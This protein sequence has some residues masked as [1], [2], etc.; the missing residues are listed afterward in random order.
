M[1]SSRPFRFCIGAENRE[2]HIPSVLLASQSQSF[3]Q[4]VNHPEIRD[5]FEDSQSYVKLK[6]VDVETFECFLQYVYTDEI[7]QTYTNRPVAMASRPSVR[8]GNEEDGESLPSAQGHND[9]TVGRD[10]EDTESR[11]RA[12]INLK[13]ESILNKIRSAFPLVSERPYIIAVFPGKPP[14]PALKYAKVFVFADRWGVHKLAEL[15]L[16]KLAKCLYSWISEDSTDKVKEIVELVEYC[17]EKPHPHKLTS[18]VLLFSA[19]KTEWNAAEKLV[20]TTR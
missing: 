15:S 18:L 16:Q 1:A 3:F 17:C 6:S 19:S 8:P 13:R 9:S 2:F 20:L 14:N 4:L 5:F 7:G 11:F 10:E 12:Q